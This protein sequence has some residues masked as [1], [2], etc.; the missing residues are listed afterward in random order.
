M[1]P[2]MPT[3]AAEEIQGSKSCYWR[4]VDPGIGVQWSQE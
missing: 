2:P 4:V 1:K 3:E